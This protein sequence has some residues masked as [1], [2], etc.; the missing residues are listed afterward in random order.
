MTEQTT[1]LA[2]TDQARAVVNLVLDG[3]SSQHSRRAY[4]KALA[5]FLA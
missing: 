4:G 1:A 2:P 3:L 5:D